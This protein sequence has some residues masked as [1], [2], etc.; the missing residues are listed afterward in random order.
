MAKM[1]FKSEI[2]WMGSGVGSDALC[3]THTVRIDEPEALGGQNTGPNP[4]EL[5]LSALGGCL[6][7]LA[8]VY[9]P[10]YGVELKSIRVDVEGDLDPDGFQGKADVRP[11]FSQIRYRFHIDSPSPAEKVEELKQ[12]AVNFCPVKD[13]LQGVEIVAA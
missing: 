10:H 2:T 6:V 3:G 4:V 12:R 11:G 9:A 1:V 5:V 7:V 8:T 13:T